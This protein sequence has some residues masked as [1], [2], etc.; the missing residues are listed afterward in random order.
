MKRMHFFGASTRR[1]SEKS[2]RLR[3][4]LVWEGALGANTDSILVPDQLGASQFEMKMT[5]SIVRVIT[6][7]PAFL[8][9]CI[10]GRLT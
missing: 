6:R 5:C 2:C 3:S 4:G 9:L 10:H 8:A 7:L 1:G